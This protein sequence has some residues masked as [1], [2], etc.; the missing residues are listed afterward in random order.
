[1]FVFV[2]SAVSM[3]QQDWIQVRAESTLRSICGTA[4]WLSILLLGCTVSLKYSPNS[5]C[6]DE[7]INKNVSLTKRQN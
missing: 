5:E 2:F 4:R 3:F 6:C 7:I 1:M